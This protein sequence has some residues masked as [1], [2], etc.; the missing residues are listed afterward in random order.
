[1]QPHHDF[2]FKYYYTRGFQLDVGLGSYGRDGLQ[3]H[4]QH[5]NR[6]PPNFE[7]GCRVIYQTKIQKKIQ[8]VFRKSER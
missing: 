6:R 2:V 4:Y 8:K 5:Y 3:N 1:M 7:A